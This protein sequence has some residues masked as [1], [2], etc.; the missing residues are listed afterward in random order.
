[1]KGYQS[2]PLKRGAAQDAWDYFTRTHGGKEPLE[3]FFSPRADFGDSRWPG[4]T[5]RYPPGTAYTPGGPIASEN[6]SVVDPY[7]IQGAK[8]QAIEAAANTEEGAGDAGN[9][10]D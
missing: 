5:A 3:I 2:R 7:E 9:T 1:M 4:W 10:N 8:R 6:F